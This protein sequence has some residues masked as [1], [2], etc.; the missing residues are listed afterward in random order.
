ME[1]EDK[2]EKEAKDSTTEKARK[3]RKDCGFFPRQEQE[4]N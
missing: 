1:G 4:V 2:R 3:V